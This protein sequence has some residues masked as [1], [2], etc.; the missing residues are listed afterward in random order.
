[1]TSNSKN[2]QHQRGLLLVISSPSG[3]GK[4]AIINRLLAADDKLTMS[5]SA[6]TRQRRPGE[7]DGQ[8]YH[9]LSVEDFKIKVNNNEFLEHAEV[10]EN[11]YGTPKEP[12][13]ENLSNGR[14][15]VFD[16]DWQ[17]A[18]QLCKSAPTDIVTV[19]VLPPSIQELEKRLNN[20]CLDDPEV[21][22]RRLLKAASEIS[23]WSQYDYV[24]VNNILEESVN[25]VRAIIKAERMKRSRQTGL[26]EFVKTMTEYR[27]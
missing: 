12:V 1:M 6:T 15:V 8:D 17:G 27:G 26:A 14:D 20:R 5:V 22:S 18:S 24:I 9:F 19:F 16:I 3:G 13:F 11:Y 10:Y 4:T 25:K 7:V 2:N 21:I 23:H